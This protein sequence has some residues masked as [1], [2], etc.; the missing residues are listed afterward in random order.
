MQTFS[1]KLEHKLNDKRVRAV[2]FDVF[3]TLV[4]R[5]VAEPGEI[6]TWLEEQENGLGFAQARHDA[7]SECRA[8]KNDEVTLAEIYACPSLQGY[9]PQAECRAEYTAAVCDPRLLALAQSCHARGLRLYAISD[10][11]LPQSELTRILK[12]CGYDFL[13]GIF[14]SAEYGVQ[15]RSGKLF[16]L[17]L[18]KTGLQAEE[19]VFV[20]D[21]WRAD[22]LGAAVAGIAGYRLPPPAAPVYLQKENPCTP[23]VQNRGFSIGGEVLG[24]LLAG[25][26]RWLHEKRGQDPSARLLFLARDMDLVYRAYRRFYPEEENISYLKVSRQSLCPA[27]L[28]EGRA[29]LAAQALPRQKLTGTQIAHYCGTSVWDDRA[30][31]LKADLGSPSL[32]AF[33]QGLPGD[34]RGLAKRYLE[35]QKIEEG[36]FLVD[37]GLG[38]TTQR[39]LEAL[40][41]HRLQGLYL[42]CDERL[43]PDRTDVY[44]FGGQCAPAQYQAVQ[45][46][47]E[48]LL[49]E[50]C[51]PT[52]GY[53]E[54]QQTGKIEVRCGDSHLSKI[55]KQILSALR[56]EALRFAEEWKKSI[57]F[58]AELSPQEAI[59]PFLALAEHPRPTDARILGNLSVEDGGVYPLAAP[60]PWPVYCRNPERFW[61]DFRDSRWKVG[62]LKRLL[63]LPLPY[64]WAYQCSKRSREG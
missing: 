48:L 16:R 51:G 27:L 54:N 24:P 5:D 20:G 43:P 21:S 19:V 18:Q 63:P 22:I 40:S 37:I 13:D 12:K 14:V 62:F 1:K 50:P 11:Y 59:E 39:L 55:Q 26:C 2:A 42:A 61:Q 7:E 36:T 47:L 56:G 32:L 31:D 6:F 23:L 35:Q 9:D 49:S 64:G 25:F 33:L 60:E 4:R 58:S 46:M 38:G 41:E 10:M 3:D 8:G 30:F 57:L 17:F 15:K 29:D 34:G 53:Q 45:P 28:A 44:L 52:V